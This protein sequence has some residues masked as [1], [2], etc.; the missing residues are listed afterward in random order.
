MLGTQ[1][2]FTIISAIAALVIACSTWTFHRWTKKQHHPDPVLADQVIEIDAKDAGEVSVEARLR[3]LNPGPI[4]IHIEK[5]SMSI[6]G[7][8]PCHGRTFIGGDQ[9]IDPTETKWLSIGGEWPRAD[10]AETR[11]AMVDLM[12]TVGTRGGELLI[13]GLEVASASVFPENGPNPYSGPLSLVTFPGEPTP[14]RYPVFS[15]TYP[16]TSLGRLWHR[17][18]HMLGRTPRQRF[19]K[20]SRGSTARTGTDN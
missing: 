5:I 16:T 2:A 11:E 9:R 7:L 1:I 17:A 15:Y 10:L 18:L 14:T 4:P 20:W 6:R 8:D 3:F 12:F 19:K 13:S